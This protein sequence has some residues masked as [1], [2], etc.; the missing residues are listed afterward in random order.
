MTA[1][2]WDHFWFIVYL[3]V[4]T[5]G[6]ALFMRL[7]GGGGST[8]Q[9]QMARWLFLFDALRFLFGLKPRARTSV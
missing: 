7:R 9:R 1:P 2:A 5:L 8:R 6:L 3:L 4:D